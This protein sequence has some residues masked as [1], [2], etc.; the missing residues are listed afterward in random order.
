M[1]T[2]TQ[3]AK[4]TEGKISRAV[5]DLMFFADMEHFNRKIPGRSKQYTDGI[6]E[7]VTKLSMEDLQEVTIRVLARAVE[8]ES[9]K[10]AR[11]ARIKAT[12]KDRAKEHMQ[13]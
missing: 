8:T 3:S 10:Q 9:E 4:T 1:V 5:A 2:Q 13:K 6:R 7:I 11:K 12:L